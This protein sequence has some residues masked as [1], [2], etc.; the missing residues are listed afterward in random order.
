MFRFCSLLLLG[1][2]L[3]L[4][5]SLS[6]QELTKGSRAAGMG[7]ANTA[8]AESANSI[9]HN[10]A[11]IA[12][13]V[14]YAIE[15]TFEYNTTGSVLNAAV[16]DSKTNPS[17]GAGVSY[18]YFIG[19]DENADLTGHDLRVG[20]GVPVVPD[21]VALGV[22]GRYLK[23]NDSD[24]EVL[25]GFTLDAGAIVKVTEGLHL[26]VAGQN[27]IDPCSLDRC[28][29]VAPTT[30]TGGDG[31]TADIFTFSGDVGADLTSQDTASMLFGA[32]I[33]ILLD[34]VPLRAG[35]ERIDSSDTSNLTF[36]AGWRT[37]A[38]GF[39]VGYKLNLQNTDDMI[40]LGS[41]SIYL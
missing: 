6:A 8:I 40:F 21:R 23:F 33:E 5:N 37:S 39:D 12:R 10:P 25:N 15:G 11:G 26:G 17:L 38:A 28:K 13:S 32:G 20:I 35:F 41:F 9:Q 14:M 7:D 36:G 30:I 27:L 1:L 3:T 22:S 16:S 31:F 19:R 34:A 2:A 24:V 29:S 4:P 18:S